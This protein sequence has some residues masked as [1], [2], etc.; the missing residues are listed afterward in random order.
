MI[1]FGVKPL[2]VERWCI[3]HETPL[4][5][6][7][8]AFRHG[9]GYQCRA[10]YLVCDGIVV[11]ECN[12]RGKMRWLRARSDVRAPKLTGRDLDGKGGRT[13]GPDEST[14]D[15]VQRAQDKREARRR[16]NERYAAAREG[17]EPAEWARLQA[18]SRRKRAA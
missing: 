10:W 9:A 4:L 7:T 13:S 15:R 6:L 17:R 11:A 8:C 12:D 14:P 3:K 16:A 18:P 5:D 1:E 2:E